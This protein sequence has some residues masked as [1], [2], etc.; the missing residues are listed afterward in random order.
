MCPFAQCAK[1]VMSGWSVDFFLSGQG[2]KEDQLL[3][4]PPPDKGQYFV[5]FQPY[6]TVNVM[7]AG[8]WV[9]KNQRFFDQFE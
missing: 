8:T 2:K 4:P 1:K 9:T 3:F 6:L 7:E 5:H